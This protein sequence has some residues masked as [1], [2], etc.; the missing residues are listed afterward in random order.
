MGI[1][2]KNISTNDKWVNVAEELGI[3]LTD[4][5]LYSVQVVG[6]AKISYS[7]TPNVI[8]YFVRNDPKVF[9]YEKLSGENF[10]INGNNLLVSMSE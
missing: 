9:T 3:T 6:S 4:N 10:Y 5:T 7:S 1:V 2:T 8:G